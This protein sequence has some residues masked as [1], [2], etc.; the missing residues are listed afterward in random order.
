M[1]E[2]QKRGDMPVK[3]PCCLSE[4]DSVFLC[5]AGKDGKYPQYQCRRCGFQFTWPCPSAEEIDRFYASGEYYSQGSGSADDPGKYSDYDRQV[6]LTLGFFR[7]WLKSFALPEGSRM[8]DVGCALGRFMALAWREF[9]FE[10]AGVELSD[11]ARKHVEEHYRGVFPVWKFLDDMPVPKKTFDVILLFDVLEH[12]NSPWELLLGLFRRGC[13]GEDTRILVTTPNCTFKDARKDPAKWQYRYPPA[14]LSFC[15]PETLR[16]IGETLLFRH[17]DIFG[18]SLTGCD[19]SAVRTMLQKTYDGYQGL[20]CCFSG[21]ALGSIFGASFPASLEE[22]R[23]SGEYL[24]ALSGF[25][26]ERNAEPFNPRFRDCIEEFCAGLTA[27]SEADKARYDEL[28][29]KY[30]GLEKAHADTLS[31]N[32]ALIAEIKNVNRDRYSMWLESLPRFERLVRLE[33]QTIELTVH[34][35]NLTSQ[36]DQLTVCKDRLES[37]VLELAGERDELRRK[38]G[39]LDR[40]KDRLEDQVRELAG[41]RDELQRKSREL[42]RYKDRLEDQVREL[43][44][45][46]DA[47]RLNVRTLGEY[48]GLLEN[49]VRDLTADRD[50][51]RR[52]TRVLDEYKD[53]LE[54]QVRELAGEKSELIGE[55]ETL[56]K[57]LREL[58]EYKKDLENQVR[59]FAAELD[60]VYRSVSYRL[61]MKLT[62]PFRACRAAAVAIREKLREWGRLKKECGA[63]FMWKCVGRNLTGRSSYRAYDVVSSIGFNCEVS[64]N[65]D[66]VNGFVDSY[67]LVWAFVHSLRHLPELIEDPMILTAEQEMKHNY[68][69][70]MV[71]FPEVDITFHCKGQPKSLLGPDGNVD[72]EK[73]RAERDE[74]KSRLAYLAGKWKKLLNDPERTALFILTPDEAECTTE[75]IIAVNRALRKYPGTELLTVLTGKE[76]S[77]SASAL[78]A[79]G[80]FVRYISHHPPHDQVAD[81]QSNDI[82]GWNRICREFRP[83]VLKRSD[84]VY[85]YEHDAS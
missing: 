45:E 17:I 38:S 9:G 44:G 83:L 71:Y 34:K 82:T 41:E 69:Y 68:S 76:K 33:K 55:M 37:Q 35:D 16:K 2:K 29:G 24:K 28:S 4:H 51:L 48:K 59:E 84:K 58:D 78:R 7:D 79:D 75:E 15:T 70:N 11:Y 27:R 50:D 74:L 67:P 63:A 52:R 6:E 23:S 53:H 85:K 5:N 30:A 19:F 77:V 14:H 66:R 18:H 46:R 47:L 26:F 3:C 54:N 39:E 13:V 42:D 32:D 56:R 36:V 61:G 57:E 25:V 20:G 12:V 65:L 60:G 10:C 21:S 40:Y 49:Q 81:A 80:I 73:A 72:E 8:L 31:A 64:Y 62:W 43:A 1:D 22:L